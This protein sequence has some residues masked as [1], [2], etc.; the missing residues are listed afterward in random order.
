MWLVREGILVEVLEP[1]GE[2]GGGEG[3]NKPHSTNIGEFRIRIFSFLV[4]ESAWVP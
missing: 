1:G 2:E 4:Q 3:C